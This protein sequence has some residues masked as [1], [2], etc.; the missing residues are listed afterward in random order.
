MSG[1][2]VLIDEENVSSG[3]SSVYL[4]GIDS[5]FDVYVV[6]FNNVEGD[7][8]ATYL[9]ARVTESGTPNTTANYDRTGKG[10]YSHT[11]FVNTSATNQTLWRING[12]GQAGTGTGEEH[13]GTL[14]LYNF[15]STTEYAFISSEVTALIADANL[16]GEQGGGVFHSTGT[17]RNGLQ[18]FMESG[19][20]DSGSF[21]LFGL[22]K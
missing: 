4:V 3:V 2:L 9:S 21:Q 10:L 12:A 22:K 5:T 6:T 19:N 16:Y 20:I 1:S 11:T 8:D 18:F 17:A 7:T 14:F 15:N 13:N